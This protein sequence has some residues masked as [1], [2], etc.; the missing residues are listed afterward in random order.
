MTEFTSQAIQQVYPNATIT[1]V[2]YPPV[3]L[4]HFQ[5][6]NT[7]RI[8]ALVSV[9]RFSPD[10]R[11]IQQIRLAAQWPNIQFHIVGFSPQHNPYFHACENEVQRLKLQ[12]VYLHPNAPLEELT[13]LFQTSRY[14]LHT[15]INEPFGITAVQAIAAGCLPLVHDSGGQRETVPEALLRY[16]SL[17]EIS[18]RLSRLEALSEKQRQDLQ[19]KLQTHVRQFRESRFHE[20]MS[21]ILKSML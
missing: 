20:Q 11:Q 3:N 15:M 18:Q 7:N 19:R 5:S 13:Q 10:K 14:F 17:N 1:D 12:N 21:V 9:G 8:S 4:R 16:T 6:K 2:I